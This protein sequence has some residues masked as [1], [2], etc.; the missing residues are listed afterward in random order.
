MT[1]N[2]IKTGDE[3]SFIVG[4]FSTLAACKV[5]AATAKAVRVRR[6]HGDRA[7]AWVPRS[8]LSLN[9]QYTVGDSRAFD[10]APWFVRKVSRSA[11]S[12]AKA[13]LGLACW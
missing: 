7:S 12:F 5:E 6:L 13:A 10:L 9:T 4:G 1:T 8:V 2:E 11:D 3:I